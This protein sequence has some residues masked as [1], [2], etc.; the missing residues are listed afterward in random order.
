M[1]NKHNITQETLDGLKKELDNLVN[2]ERLKIIQEIKDARANGD[3][4]ENAD[5][6]SALEQQKVIEG[7]IAEIKSIIHN[8]V[9]ISGEKG[10]K[11]KNDVVKIGSKIKIL[12]IEDNTEMIYEILGSVDNNPQLGKISNECPLARAILDKK[13]GDEVEIQN[14]EYPYRVKILEVL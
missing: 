4:S 13:V 1:E 6:E 3:L 8:H 5:Y 11:G 14:V 7:R 2:V 10:G 9:I 12:E